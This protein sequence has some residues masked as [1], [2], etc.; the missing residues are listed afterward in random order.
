M[1]AK[2]EKWQTKDKHANKVI[3][4]LAKEYNISPLVV[5]QIVFSP[6]RFTTRVIRDPRDHRPIR[7]PHLGVFTTKRK[8]L[9][10]LGDVE[11]MG[12]ILLK[13]LDYT[14]MLMFSVLGFQLADRESVRRIIEEAVKNNDVDKLTLIF[15]EFIIHI[16]P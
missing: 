9:K 6:L 4:D 12:R 14:Y 13:H 1:K 11:E 5:R 7:I 3:S 10:A 8:Y 16:T 15:K 2:V